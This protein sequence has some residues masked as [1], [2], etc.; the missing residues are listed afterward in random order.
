[1][2][3]REIIAACSEI[4]TKHINTPCGQNVELLNVKRSGTYMKQSLGFNG[5]EDT[6]L[7]LIITFGKFVITSGLY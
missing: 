1:M 7:C 3:S 2:P 6:S 5:L 4:N